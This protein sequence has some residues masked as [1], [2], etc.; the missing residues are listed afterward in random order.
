MSI[1]TALEGIDFTD[2]IELISS[3]Q[4]HM[5]ENTNRLSDVCSQ[6]W[7]TIELNKCDLT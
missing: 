5:Q 6:N 1:F 4:D 3:T 2:D 7:T